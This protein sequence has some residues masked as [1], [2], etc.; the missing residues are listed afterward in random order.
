MLFDEDLGVFIDTSFQFS[1]HIKQVC[2]QPRTAD[3]S[4]LTV[5]HDSGGTVT[6]MATLMSRVQIFRDY[7]VSVP[8]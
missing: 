1:A 3:M 7:T 2:A 5:N 6:S 4:V 8:S